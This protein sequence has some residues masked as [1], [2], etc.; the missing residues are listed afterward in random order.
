MGFYE[1]AAWGVIVGLALMLVGGL[2]VWAYGSRNKRSTIDVPMIFGPESE[3]TR[4]FHTKLVRWF[5]FYGCSATAVGFVVL[6]CSGLA[7]S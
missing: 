2:V 4:V 5:L 1:R 6:V 3:A 7:F